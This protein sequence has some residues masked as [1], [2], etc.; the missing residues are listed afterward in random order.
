MAV[1]RL[2][3]PQKTP[4]FE[5]P[6]FPKYGSESKKIWCGCMSPQGVPTHQK[7]AK[8]EMKIFLT[9]DFYFD[10]SQ[11]APALLQ[12]NWAYHW[13]L[14]VFSLKL[15]AWQL[16]PEICQKTGWVSES[17]SWV[18]RAANYY[19]LEFVLS[20]NHY[21][22]DETMELHIQYCYHVVPN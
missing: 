9:I 22:V 5:P 7:W 17:K 8:L 16:L 15:I 11:N 6:Y 4:N 10:F 14:L 12:L 18:K 19:H 21:R 2:R 3:V 13:Y 20:H 1:Q